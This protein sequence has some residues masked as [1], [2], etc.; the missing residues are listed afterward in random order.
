MVLGL[1]EDKEKNKKSN[2]APTRPDSIV[3]NVRQSAPTTLTA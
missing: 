1:G 2:Q 3:T